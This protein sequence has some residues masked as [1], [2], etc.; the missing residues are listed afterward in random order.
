MLPSNLYF[1]FQRS[2]K[3]PQEMCNP[4]TL[5]E[6]RRILKTFSGG[7]EEEEERYSSLSE[8]L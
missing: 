5:S 3:G 6:W 2:A 8:A 7:E 1:A 4:Q